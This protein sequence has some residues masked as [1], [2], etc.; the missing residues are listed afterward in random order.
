MSPPLDPRLDLIFQMTPFCDTAADIGTDH[1]RLICALVESGRIRRGI[2]ADLNEKPLEKA[3]REAQRRGLSHRLEFLQ[4]DGLTGISPENLGAVIIAGMGGETII[5]I[6]ESWPYSQDQG[7]TWL[8]QP[9][10]KAERLRV[11]LWE[12]GFSLARESCCTASGRVYSVIEARCTGQV[13]PHRDWEQ[14]LGAICPGENSHTLRYVRNKAAELERIAAGLASAGTP[15]ALREAAALRGAV[16]A[17]G[18]QIEKG[19]T[20][21]V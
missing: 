16:N 7:I 9:M 6:L 15:E 2:A 11:W 4:T 19:E 10:T 8:L 18:A 3:R 12:H 14:Y 17:I 1:G 20:G 13:L 21:N 5:H